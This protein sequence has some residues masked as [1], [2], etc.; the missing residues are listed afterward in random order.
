MGEM[1]AAAPGLSAAG[2]GCSLGTATVHRKRDHKVAISPSTEGDASAAAGAL[3]WGPVKGGRT[4]PEGHPLVFELSGGITRN[5]ANDRQ[6]T[7][8][9]LGSL[10]LNLSGEVDR[11]PATDRGTDRGQVGCGA[12][13][14]RVGPTRETLG[15]IRQLAQQ[16]ATDHAS[17]VPQVTG[18]VMAEPGSWLDTR[19]GSDKVGRRQATGAGSYGIPVHPRVVA[20]IRVATAIARQWAG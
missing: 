11:E 10:R 2:S 5:H 6:A 3:G 12:Q 8:S 18:Y 15:S 14:V 19:H 9:Q 16:I 13:M 4:L 20:S 17:L 7:L 1:G